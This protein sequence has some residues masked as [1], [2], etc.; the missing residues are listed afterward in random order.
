M[1][2]RRSKL[3]LFVIVVVETLKCRLCNATYKQ[4]T[5]FFHHIQTV[6]KSSTTYSCSICSGQFNSTNELADHLKFT[7]QINHNIDFHLNPTRRPSFNTVFSCQFCS[8]K[9]HSGFELNQHLLHE[10]HEER[11]SSKIPFELDRLI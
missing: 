6:H 10:H 1:S 11:K 2:S 5:D 7:H 3:I 8:S 9:F 4:R